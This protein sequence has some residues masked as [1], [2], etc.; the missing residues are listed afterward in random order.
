MP[1]A[2]LTPG[3]V[4]VRH[5]VEPASMERMAPAYATER[6]PP[7]SPPAEAPDGVGAVEGARRLITAP[8]HVSEDRTQGQL[9]G[10]D[11]EEAEPGHRAADLCAAWFSALARSR[12]SM[13]GSTPPARAGTDTT[14]S[15]PVIPSAI[16]ASAARTNSSCPVSFHSG[17][18]SEHGQP[19]A[20]NVE[21]VGQHA[22]TD[23]TVAALDARA[24]DSGKSAASTQAVA[25]VHPVFAGVK[26][27][28]PLRRR[29]LSTCL[30]PGVA[31]RTRKPCVLRR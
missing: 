6:E 25:A 7:A 24:T 10:A 20:E 23:E 19:G 5:R 18:S 4:R 17:A 28:R 1:T 9:V 8:A 11:E 29:A 26:R 12:P 15:S 27:F 13:A 22:H 21:T 16:G 30:P 2:R 3:D 31:M 14:A